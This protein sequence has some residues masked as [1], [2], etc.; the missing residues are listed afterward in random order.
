MSSLLFK[1]LAKNF[2]FL[3]EE[4]QFYNQNELS[5]HYGVKLPESYFAFLNSFGAGT[6]GGF[7]QFHPPGHMNTHRERLEPFMDDELSEMVDENDSGDIL[8]FATTDN[9]DMLGWKLEEMKL[10]I[11]P[12]IFEIPTR[13][14]DVNEIANNVGDLISGLIE[15]PPN[16]LLNMKLT[17]LKRCS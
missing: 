1:E 7:F 17:H 10:N 2:T 4:I 13:T 11:E 9:G 14:F 6:L 3:P 15:N 16:H 8:I 5:L 12:K